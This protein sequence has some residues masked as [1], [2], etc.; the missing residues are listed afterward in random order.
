VIAVVA[1]VVVAGAAAVVGMIVTCVV[2]ATLSN[3]ESCPFAAY[4]PVH[5]ESLQQVRAPVLTQI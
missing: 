1:I 5:L 4:C 3:T 2:V